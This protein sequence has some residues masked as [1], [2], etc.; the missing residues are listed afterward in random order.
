MMKNSFLELRPRDSLLYSSCTRLTLQSWCRFVLSFVFV[1][2]ARSWLGMMYEGK[3]PEEIPCGIFWIYRS[4]FYL[5][6]A[7]RNTLG[8][9]LGRVG[10]GV[11]D[12][13]GYIHWGGFLSKQLSL[14]IFLSGCFV[15]IMDT[16]GLDT[17]RTERYLTPL[18]KVN[19]TWRPDNTSWADTKKGLDITQGQ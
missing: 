4:F 2:A 9:A 8:E 5:L 12:V 17:G 13:E 6:L 10:F 19:S 1:I 16:A 11:Q 15:R 18:L 3:R 7:Q 14:V